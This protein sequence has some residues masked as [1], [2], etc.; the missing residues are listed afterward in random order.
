MFRRILNKL[1]GAQAQPNLYSDCICVLGMHRSGTSCLTGIMQGL[2]V[3]LGD[4][5]TENPANLK[6]NREHSRVVFLNDAVLKWN[7]AAWDNP[8]VVRNWTP[9]MAAE[10]TAIIEELRNR[11]SGHWGFKDTRT[12]FT[13]PFWLEA[14]DEPRFIGTFRHPQRV[15]LSLNQRDGS[16]IEWGLDLWYR[17]NER[18]LQVTREYGCALA[19]FDLPDD[20]YIEDVLA[21]LLGLGLDASRVAAGR[22][23]FDPALRNQSTAD[24]SDAELPVRVADLYNRLLEYSRT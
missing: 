12:L 19:D 20:A 21:K 2:G 23:F 8:A 11:G 1:A 22:E 13:L 5:Y 10:R 6:G 18:L 15:A 17:Y 14:L 9:E 3:E 4:V 7:D 24:V 16:P